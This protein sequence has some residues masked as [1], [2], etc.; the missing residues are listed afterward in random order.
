M[1]KEIESFQARL[2]R[3]L[4]KVLNGQSEPFISILGKSENC[5]PAFLLDVLHEMETRGLVRTKNEGVEG[6]Y[7]LTAHAGA[8]HD[9]CKSTQLPD[10]KQPKHSILDSGYFQDVVSGIFDSLPEPGL[11]YS[12]WWFSKPTYA[13]LVDLLFHLMRK[14]THVA[15]AGA[16][17]LG[18][19]FSHCATSPMTII[20]VDDILLR[21]IASHIERQAQFVCR[22]ISNPLDI[23]LKGKF[24]IVFADPPWSS[25]NLKTFFVRSSEMLAM[26]GTLVI[27]FPPVFTR[28]SARAERKSL[29]RMAELLGL[30]FRTELKGFTEYSV[31][32]FEYRAYKEHSIELNQPWR[33]GDVL[34]FEK[35]SEVTHS[36]DIPIEACYRWDQ[37]DYDMTRLFLKRNGSI[38]EGP[39]HIVPVPGKNDFAYD[40]TSSRTELWKQA[41][42]VSTGN[43][44]ASVSGTKQ[45]GSILRE[46]LI[47]NSS[48]CDAPGHLKDVLPETHAAISVLLNNPENEDN[49]QLESK[50]RRQKERNSHTT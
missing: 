16:S 11:V 19:V 46:L 34:V 47:R 8:F 42:L 10:S 35:R 50:W 17:T 32:L 6:E 44:I 39:A 48:M 14:D 20:D 33:K 25:S 9:V 18:A 12:Q 21:R 26:A 43:Q 27:S 45:L 13:K 30:S 4:L 29:L 24:D 49:Q 1:N 41:C 31:P 15:F 23:C 37:Y 7:Q 2:I 40:S 3:H 22:D 28:P 5:D 38:E 36:A